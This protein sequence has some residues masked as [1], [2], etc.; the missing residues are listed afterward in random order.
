MASIFAL[1]EGALT[2]NNMEERA[3][4]CQLKVFGLNLAT[5]LREILYQLQDGTK[6]KLRAREGCTV[7]MLSEQ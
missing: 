1:S 3:T 5:L 2:T 6:T 7:Q 4:V